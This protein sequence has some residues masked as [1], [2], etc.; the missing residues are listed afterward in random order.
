MAR[1]WKEKGALIQVNASSFY[2][3]RKIKNIANKLLKEKLIDYIASDVHSF[4]KNYIKQFVNDYKDI[5][6]FDF[7]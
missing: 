3:S 7:K 1:E 5:S 6:Y 4:R 2:G